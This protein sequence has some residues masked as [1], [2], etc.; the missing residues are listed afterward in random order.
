MAIDPI[1]ISRVSNQLRDGLFLSNIRQAQEQLLKMQTQIST[2]KYLN[3]PSVDPSASASVMHLQRQLEQLGQYQKNIDHATSYLDIT[4]AALGDVGD[5]I[6]QAKEIALENTPMTATAEQRQAAAALVDGLIDQIVNVGNREFGNTYIFGGQANT[7]APFED[8]GEFVGYFGDID[9][10]E[11]RMDAT[12]T[13]PFTITGEEAFGALS[14]QIQGWRDLDPILTTDTRLTDVEGY[15]GRGVRLG[16]LHVEDGLGGQ[17]NVDLSDADN[18]GDVIDKINDIGSASVVAG[19]NA[20]GDGLEI[21]TVPA[22]T[23]TVSDLSGGTTAT[24]LGLAATAAGPGATLVG[25]DI[26]PLLTET[27]L[28]ASLNGGAGID[29][30]GGLQITNAGI[31]RTVSLAGLDTVG[32]VLNAINHADAHVRA[33]IDRE[34]NTLDVLNQ[35]S[36]TAMMLAEN[37]GNSA[38]D[39]G[40]RSFHYGLSLDELNDGAGVRIN[41]SGDD[42]HI[43][44][45][46]GSEIDV[47]L[48]GCRTVQDV[49]DAINTDADNVAMGSPLTA[50]V[51]TDGNGIRLTDT[52]GGASAIRVE[53]IDGRWAAGDLGLLGTG[54]A[55]GEL[56]GEDVMPISADGVITHLISLREALLAD[57]TA[58]I[59]SAGGKLDADHA[60]VAAIRGMVG[61]RTRMLEDRAVR[62]DEEIL[63]SQALVSEL[64]D[65]DF[66]EAISRFSTLQATYQASLVAASQIMT[67]S[68]LDFLM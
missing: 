39:L 11:S 40:I 53:D 64:A 26:N 2:G 52:L 50:S 23:I 33:S 10:I 44:C 68:L 54:P 46:D 65:L 20:A 25:E 62:T 13:V 38:S 18:I 41:D 34:N 59:T 14:S 12:N 36:G 58:G 30:A 60:R 19:I 63:A 66:A 67:V 61:V 47:D 42:L 31:T 56:D 16:T 5:L 35:L 24:D 28:L 55:A 45:S 49:L 7:A 15:L 4:D 1:A 51:R 37:G 6:I 22:A 8:V 3:R 43:L 48:D 32:D 9:A 29:T 27:T 17:W 21:A 57:D